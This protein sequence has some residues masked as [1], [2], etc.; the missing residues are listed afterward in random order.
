MRHSKSLL[1][2]L[3]VVIGSAGT[4]RAAD[5][6]MVPSNL[7]PEQKANLL[8]F[9]QDHEKPDRYMPAGARIVRPPSDSAPA[10]DAPDS[11]LPPPN[12]TIKQYTVQIISQRPV[13]DQPTPQR[14]DVYYYRPNPEQG[15][16]GITVKHT[17]DLTTGKQ[18]GDTE[19]LLNHHTPLSREE[20]AD[21]VKLARE[22]SADVKQ[23]Y[24]G[25][26]E[27]AVRWEYLQLMVRKKTAAVEP[28]DRVVRLVFTIADGG[29]APSPVPV[30]VDLT[31]GTVV[32]DAR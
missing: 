22:K 27:T 10:A 30:I 12:T 2:L 4:L 31:K 9:L 6:D 32:P 1:P 17:V 25:R 29:A 19:V 28:G 20:L 13:P 15:K 16:P 23:L 18:V 26:E 24:V 5:A 21:A 8:R 7:P 11:A 14:V 3:M